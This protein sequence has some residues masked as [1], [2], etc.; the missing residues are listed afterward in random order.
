MARRPKKSVPELLKVKGLPG[1]FER[2][3]P[4]KS[5]AKKSKKA[6]KNPHGGPHYANWTGYPEYAYEQFYRTN[7]LW[8]LFGGEDGNKVRVVYDRMI[9]IGSP[10]YPDWSGVLRRGNV[11]E[12]KTVED[13]KR[14]WQ[15]ENSGQ[16]RLVVTKLVVDDKLVDPRAFFGSVPMR[17]AANTIG[18]MVYDEIPLNAGPY[19]PGMSS[20]GVTGRAATYHLPRYEVGALYGY[21]M[22]RARPNVVHYVPHGGLRK[23]L[24]A[25]FEGMSGAAIDS[26]IKRT[27]RNVRRWQK[28]L[29]KNGS[30]DPQRS[31]Y[32]TNEIKKGLEAHELAD[33]V[34]EERQKSGAWRIYRHA[35]PAG[36]AEAGRLAYKLQAKE[37]GKYRGREGFSAALREAWAQVKAAGIPKTARKKKVVLPAKVSATRRKVHRQ[38]G[39]IDR[40][41]S[42]LAMAGEGEM[43]LAQRRREAELIEQR[44]KLLGKVSVQYNPDGGWDL[45][46][47]F[48]LVEDSHKGS[49]IWRLHFRGRD[50]GKY[51]MTPERATAL[52]HRLRSGDLVK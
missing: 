14:W 43:T 40:E 8:S 28:E 7:P 35:P 13:V 5:Y 33:E 38:L 51:A 47:G 12:F 15:K 26:F 23:A 2:Y 1:L 18:R 49:R 44:E 42:K 50:T 24:R 45:A 10:G 46:P 52:S 11:E 48:E 39:Q 6:T 22:R 36:S 9:D 20:Y 19:V 34:R 32:L 17:A 31:F 37:P 27:A 29:E 30:L 25:E 16:F 41:L 21:G 3:Y 4:E